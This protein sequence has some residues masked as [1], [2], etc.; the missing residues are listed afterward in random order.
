M[1][2][3]NNDGVRIYYE[4]TG[5]GPP[6]V[7][8]HGSF[9]SGED[10]KDF[11]YVDALSS[12]HQV[13]LIDARGHG[14]SD[15]PH[16]PTAYDLRLRVMDVAAVLDDIGLA[17]ANYFGYSMGGWIGFGVAKYAPERLNSMILGGAHPY[18]ENMTAFRNLIPQEPNGFIELLKPAFG[19]HLTEGIQQRCMLNDLEAL[20]ALTQDRPSLADALPNISMPC[21]IFVG[22]VDPRFPMVK[23]CVEQLPSAAFFSLP[24]LGHIAAC[25]RSELVLPNIRRFLAGLGE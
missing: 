25:A 10:W 1:S 23:K 2:Y 15:K 13:I 9:G 24:G 5:S 8:H 14:R 21:M 11:G 22:D 20:R 3:A 19:P 17:T 7:L 6:L 18:P 4:L 16:E 12:N